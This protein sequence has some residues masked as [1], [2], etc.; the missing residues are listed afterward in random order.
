MEDKSTTAFLDYGHN[1][2]LHLPGY[3][4]PVSAYTYDAHTHNNEGVTV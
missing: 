4:R 2:K 3:H 1:E